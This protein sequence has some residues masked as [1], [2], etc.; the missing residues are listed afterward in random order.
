[1]SLRSPQFG[2]LEKPLL[3]GERTNGDTRSRRTYRMRLPS[4][5][6]EDDVAISTEKEVSLP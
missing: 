3:F 2:V 4:V 6:D 5:A 1:M